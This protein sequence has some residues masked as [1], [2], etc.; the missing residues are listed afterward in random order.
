MKYIIR[1]ILLAY[2]HGIAMASFIPPDFFLHVSLAGDR[3]NVGTPAPGLPNT[4]VVRERADLTQET[5][6][7]ALFAHFDLSSLTLTDVAQPGFSAM[8]EGELVGRLNTINPLQVNVGRVEA[9]NTWDDSLAAGT[10]PLFEWGATSLDQQILVPNVQT[11]TTNTIFSADVT[12]IISDLV[13]GAQPDNGL[14]LF[15]T[16]PL[17]QA[18]GFEGLQLNVSIPEPGSAGLLLSGFCLVLLIRRRI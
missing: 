7:V 3:D 8:L 2:C 1:L 9:A 6:R 18:A 15:G 12:A 4:Y 17:F 13:T 16:P 10:V 11:A 5:L 14:V